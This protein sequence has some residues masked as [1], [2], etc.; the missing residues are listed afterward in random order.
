MLLAAGSLLAYRHFIQHWFEPSPELLRAEDAGRLLPKETRILDSVMTPEGVRFQ[1]VTYRTTKHRCIDVVAGNV[2]SP[3]GSVGGC[4]F[5]E[6]DME[7]TD[8]DLTVRGTGGIGTAEGHFSITQGFARRG[9]RRYL[10]TYNDGSSE[11]H[12]LDPQLRAWFAVSSP[13]RGVASWEA[14]R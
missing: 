11:V 1:L 2:L 13:S 14:I 5:S 10:I 12:K 8:L 4:G 7:T 9:I 3:R 6:E